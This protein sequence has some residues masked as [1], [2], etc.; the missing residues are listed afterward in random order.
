MLNN[1]FQQ[2]FKQKKQKKKTAFP[3]LSSLLINY[4]I[5]PTSDPLNICKK[6]RKSEILQLRSRQTEQFQK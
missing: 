5:I 4:N 1:Y 2:T 3:L 6:E